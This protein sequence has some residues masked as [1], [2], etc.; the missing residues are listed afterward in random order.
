MLK[1][2]TIL[3]VLVA[4]AA[5]DA[6]AWSIF[7]SKEGAMRNRLSSGDKLM[8]R[9]DEAFGKSELEKAG[10]LYQRAMVHFREVD[11]ADPTFMDGL[12]ALRIAYCAGQWTNV[13]EAA[14]VAVTDGKNVDVD[15]DTDDEEDE[16]DD[17]EG[18][19]DVPVVI[20]KAGSEPPPYDMRNF[21]HDLGEAKMLIEDGNL[22]AAASL[23]IPMLR[24]DPTNREVRLLVAI[25]R[26]R[27]NRFD[28]AIVALED[29]RGRREDLPVLLALSGAYAGAG[30][31]HDALLALDVAIRLAPADPNAYLNMAWLTLSMPADADTLKNAETYYRQ[32]IKRGAARDRTL[33]ARIG[34]EKW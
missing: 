26:T 3:S 32:A 10:A 25:V 27:Q 24:H 19:E 15:D 13:M 2:R 14:K 8:S 16:D 11:A 5:L 1:L 18:D 31:H 20:K 17:G 7:G 34:L 33:E 29:M 28:E 9:A 22:S 12:A 6:C 21:A 4:V 30:R 23:L